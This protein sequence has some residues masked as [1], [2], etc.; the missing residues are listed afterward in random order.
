MAIR[1]EVEAETQQITTKNLF[2]RLQLLNINEKIQPIIMAECGQILQEMANNHNPLI[3]EP[4]KMS[5]PIPPLEFSYPQQ[6]QSTSPTTLITT[7]NS[8]ESFIMAPSTPECLAPPS[9]ELPPLPI[10]LPSTLQVPPFNYHHGQLCHYQH[11]PEPI[12]VAGSSSDESDRSP[13]SSALSL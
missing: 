3:Q 11:C 1:L 2:G 7:F 13:R 9:D 10:L 4:S 12:Y 6:S 8:K 5:E